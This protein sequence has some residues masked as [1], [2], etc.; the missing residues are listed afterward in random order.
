MS[1]LALIKSKIRSSILFAG[2]YMYGYVFWKRVLEFFFRL[3]ECDVKPELFGGPRTA[4]SNGPIGEE[5]PQDFWIDEG[6]SPHQ[7]RK[8]SR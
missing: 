5:M 1:I 3:S 2:R 7:K 4:K 8:N 6:G